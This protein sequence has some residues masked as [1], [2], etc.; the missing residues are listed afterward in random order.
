MLTDEELKEY[1]TKL[2]VKL[3]RLYNFKEVEVFVQSL[4][5]TIG[6]TEFRTPKVFKSINRV[7][8]AVRF[9]DKEKLYF[10]SFPLTTALKE[11]ETKAN[12]TMLPIKAQYFKFPEIKKIE[13]TSLNIFD[14]RIAEQDDDTLVQLMED[15]KNRDEQEQNTIIDGNILLTYE[16]KLITNSSRALAFERSTWCDLDLRVIYRGK[17]MITSAEKH[18]TRRKIPRNTENII[19]ELTNIAFQRSTEQTEIKNIFSPVIFSPR[20]FSAIF[21]FAFVPQLGKPDSANLHE[22]TFTSNF[23]LV[24]DGTIPALPNSTAFDDEGVKQSRTEVVNRGQFITYLNN[25]QTAEIDEKKTGNSFRVKMYERFPRSYQAYPN[26]FPSNLII[27]EGT[28]SIGQIMDD[29]DEGILVNSVQGYMAADCF[30]GNFSVSSIE[31]Y[32]IENGSIKGTLPMFVIKGNIFDIL[33]NEPQFSKEQEVIRTPLTPYS[34]VSP[35]VFTEQTTIY[36]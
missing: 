31:A 5:Q 26:V 13:F 19:N 34:I 16:R 10:T 27:K 3:E 9:F 28:E 32:M 17:K 21:S 22:R 25:S 18:L 6:G 12:L 8:C 35:Y 15:I 11:I 24:D 2:L 7:G 20:A 4:N 14:K 36:S 30:T 23:S 1:A 29:I 33:A